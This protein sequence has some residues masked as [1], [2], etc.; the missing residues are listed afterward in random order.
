MKTNVHI[1]FAGH[2]IPGGVDAILGPT[3]CG[4]DIAEIKKY[5]YGKD[6]IGISVDLTLEDGD[7]RI[8]KVLALLAPYKKFHSVD[9]SDEY[10]EEDLQSA[11]LLRLGGWIEATAFGNPDYGTTYD[12]SNACLA[13]GTGGRQTSPLIVSDTDMRKVDKHLVA[14]TTYDDLLI[15]DTDVERL[16]AAN[17]TGALF[18]PVSMKRKKTGEVT[19]LRWQQAVI[20]NVLPPMASSSF[21]ERKD[22]CTSCRRG[23][24]TP[25]SFQPRRFV[26]RAEDLT[27]IKDFNLTWESLGHYTPTKEEIQ[28][29][30]RRSHPQILVTPKVMNLLRGKTKKEKKYEGCS[31]TPVW[32]EGEE[33]WRR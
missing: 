2:L 20:D 7:N 26:Y 4:P 27:N 3:E 12:M 9:R 25:I 15:R 32:I 8:A 33:P 10:T 30:F 24:F 31:F 6:G 22:V 23:G 28:R 16:L 1:W 13:C 5:K 21:L 18:W 17:V 19:E 29:G 14:V 11:R